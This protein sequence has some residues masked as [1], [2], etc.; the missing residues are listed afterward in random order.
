MKTNYIAHDEVYKK[1]KAAG[2]PGWQDEETLK[3]TLAFRERELR[4]PNAPQE[5]K[6]LELG[7]GAGDVTLWLAEQGYEASGVDISPS[8]IA[9]AKEKARSRDLVVDFQ[10]GSVLDLD[11]HQRE[12]FDLVLDGYCL[13]CIIGDD[14]KGF[15][16][17]ARRVLKLGAKFHVATMCGEMTSP[18][19]LKVFDETSRCVI[20]NQGIATR[21]IGLHETILDEIKSA[22]F[23]IDNWRI[24][25]RTDEETDMDE[26]I[27]W[28][29]KR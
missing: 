15:F 23:T 26:L 13:H 20:D 12:A 17:S 24:K 3:K 2:L 10:V 11:G 14:R 16:A 22:G 7:C 28:A 9:W 29:T 25:P 5:G 27:V 8:A 1:K 6:V 19:L 18:S 4:S 21:Y